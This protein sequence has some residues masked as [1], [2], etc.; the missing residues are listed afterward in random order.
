MYKVINN[1]MNFICYNYLPVLADYVIDT[2]IN[3]YLNVGITPLHK[4]PR[5]NISLLKD[6]DKI[7]IKIYILNFYK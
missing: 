6:G 4:Y 1:Y 5:L 7:F 2:P 3:N